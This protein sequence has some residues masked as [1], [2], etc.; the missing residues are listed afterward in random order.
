MKVCD[1]NH[2]GFLRPDFHCF[3][4]IK[5][6]WQRNLNHRK[7]DRFMLNFGHPKYNPALPV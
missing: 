1:V 7:P 2:I 6:M 3:N 4:L 5:I